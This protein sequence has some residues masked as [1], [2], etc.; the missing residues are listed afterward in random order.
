MIRKTISI[1]FAL[2][3]VAMLAI[4]LTEPAIAATGPAILT[5][6]LAVGA[7]IAWPKRRSRLF[8]S[9]VTI[10]V[11]FGRGRVFTRLDS[12]ACAPA[13]RWLDL[14]PQSIASTNARRSSV[15]DTGR[16]SSAQRTAS[17]A[18]A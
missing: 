1:A 9:P 4:T 15:H 16:R 14:A 17:T 10:P 3:A 6:A 7:S 5:L 13:D 2:L 12:A 11:R 18:R 8:P